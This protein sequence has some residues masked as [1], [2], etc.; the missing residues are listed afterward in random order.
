MGGLVAGEIQ[1]ERQT[2]GFLGIMNTSCCLPGAVETAVVASRGRAWLPLP[3]YPGGPSD[4]HAS[5]GRGKS[6]GVAGTYV[7][8]LS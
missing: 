8:I 7:R 1:Q 3:P 5:T 2:G 4:V 6:V